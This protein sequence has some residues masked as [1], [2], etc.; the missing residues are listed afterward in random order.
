MKKQ[1]SPTV[2]T[3][4]VAK[5]CDPPLWMR[6]QWRLSAVAGSNVLLCW[7]PWVSAEQAHAFYTWRYWYEIRS[8]RPHCPFLFLSVTTTT[9]RFLYLVRLFPVTCSAHEVAEYVNRASYCLIISFLQTPLHWLFYTSGQIVIAW[10]LYFRDNGICQRETFLHKCNIGVMKKFR[11]TK[12]FVTPCLL[13]HTH[14]HTHTH[15]Y[16]RLLSDLW[17]VSITETCML[18]LQIWS[19]TYFMWKEEMTSSKY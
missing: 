9:L 11:F 17:G 1:S 6:L 14:T 8:L 3:V 19:N 4:R 15:T 10:N 13:K 18:D 12:Y 16:A 2:S 5:P 7:H